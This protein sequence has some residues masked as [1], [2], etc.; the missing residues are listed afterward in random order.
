MKESKIPELLSKLERQIKLELVK[1]L[2]AF[3]ISHFREM[4]HVIWKINMMKTLKKKYQQ[5]K[6]KKKEK[7]E[8]VNE[9][10]PKGCMC[11]LAIHIQGVKSQWGWAGKSKM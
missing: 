2:Q 10:I 9:C 11:N 1:K 3:K 6:K 7:C 8:E 5:L 4:P